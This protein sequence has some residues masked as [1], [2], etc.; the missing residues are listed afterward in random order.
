MDKAFKRVGGLFHYLYRS[1]PL[2]F[3]M[4]A[5]REFHD[6]FGHPAPQ[7]PT[8]L[9]PE[10]VKQRYA[11]S[12]EENDEFLA[13]TT[14]VDQADAALDKLYFAL[15]DLVEMGLDPSPLFQ[16]V[17]DANMAKLG[18]DGKPIPHPTMAG[19][20]GKPAG[21]QKPEPW[22]SAEVARQIRLADGTSTNREADREPVVYGEDLDALALRTKYG[23]AL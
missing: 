4:N 18:P 3:A 15:G 6:A 12:A 8:K 9:T 1:G 5:V 20:I 23:T 10:R 14:L 7:V 19:K 21:W 11:F 2:M 13:A 16:I 22:L 17:Q